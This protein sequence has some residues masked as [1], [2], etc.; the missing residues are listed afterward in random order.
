MKERI[1]GLGD[2]LRTGIGTAAGGVIWRDRLSP[3]LR[4][5]TPPSET[6][7]WI[8]EVPLTFLIAPETPITNES[9]P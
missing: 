7:M 8:V 1:A 3:T 5:G 9:S 6:T 4:W 2:A